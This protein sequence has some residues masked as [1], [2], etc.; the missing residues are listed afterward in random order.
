[1]K[2]IRVFNQSFKVKSDENEGQI[3]EIAEY[4]NSKIKEVQESTKT[5]ATL[6][7]AILTALNIAYDYYS[8]LGKYE[9][10]ALKYEDRAKELINKV[11]AV[12]NDTAIQG[13]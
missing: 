6:N 12:L 13:Q 8:I 3:T 11:N 9:G 7:V 1:M 4:V 10:V 5:V 2:E